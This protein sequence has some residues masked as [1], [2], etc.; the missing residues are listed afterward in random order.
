[1]LVPRWDDAE[2]FFRMAFENEA[3]SPET[4]RNFARCI[5][6]Q[7]RRSEPHAAAV[8]PL[9]RQYPD[10]GVLAAQLAWAMIRDNKRDDAVAML[11]RSRQLGV[12]PATV[13]SPGLIRQVEEEHGRKV[14]DKA[15]RQAESAGARPRRHT[16]RLTCKLKKK[17]RQLR[18]FFVGIGWWSLGF[19]V[20]YL[21]VMG[22]MCLAGILLAY[23][24]RGL[25]AAEM[26]GTP[27]EEEPSAGPL[28]RSRRE[29]RLT[30]FYVLALF[31][32]L[33]FFYAALPLVF[34]GLL[35]VFL[36]TLVLSIFVRR[37]SAAQDVHAMLLRASGGGM[38]AVF[39][40]LFAQGDS[41]TLGVRPSRKECPKLFTAIYDVAERVDTDP[42]DEVWIAP[43]AEFSVY[44]KGRGPFGMFGSRKRV[45]TIGLCVLSFLTIDEFKSILAHEFAHFSHA[46]T[47]WHRFLFQV[48]LSLNT[49]IKEMARTGGWVTYL[50]PFFWFFWL[51]SRSFGL[52]ASGFSRSREFLADRMACQLYGS[53][54]FTE[55]LR[56]VCTDGA[57]F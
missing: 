16:V 48:H 22:V 3:K 18:R 55:A 50:N 30:R 13:I 28:F 24:T 47:F 8:E 54:V 27:D 15:K 31:S 4:A 12:D 2:A 1:M 26:L 23:W 35:L 42:P 11:E 45:L 6:E 21:V 57:G 36:A 25:R 29:S 51:Y 40:A 46:D 44:Q 52:L 49:A 32:G 17:P 5:N 19:T 56:K 38:G 14:N 10:D 9:V 53:D 34:V 43:G 33:I 20:F 37:N 7:D 39:E 41:R